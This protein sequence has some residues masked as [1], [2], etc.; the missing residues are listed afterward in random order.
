VVV[1]GLLDE[2]PSDPFPPTC[3]SERPR[4]SSAQRR[5]ADAHE[6]EGRKR[7]VD[8]KKT[9]FMTYEVDSGLFDGQP[10]FL[11]TTIL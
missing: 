5:A 10:V 11:R 8:G 1:G 9:V 2:N 3:L 6:R 4:A 7:G